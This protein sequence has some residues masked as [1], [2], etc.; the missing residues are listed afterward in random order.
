MPTEMQKLAD[1]LKQA[2]MTPMQQH[3][4]SDAYKAH[5]GSASAPSARPMG[6]DPHAFSQHQSMM[7]NPGAYVPQGQIS[8]GLELATPPR[9]YKR[10][11]EIDKLAACLKDNKSW[12]PASKK[13][14]PSAM[15]GNEDGAKTSE[16][17]KLAELMQKRAG[18]L[19]QGMH[20][21]NTAV[22][23]PGMI[24]R[25]A[26]KL[27]NAAGGGFRG[28]GAVAE[29]YAPG[30]AMI[31]APVAAGALGMS[32]MGGNGQQQQ[33]PGQVRMAS[34]KTGAARIDEL[35]KAAWSMTEP[36]HALDAARYNADSEASHKKVKAHGDYADAEGNRSDILTALDVTRFLGM[37]PFGGGSGSHL[38]PILDRVNSRHNDYA[39]KKH[40]KGENAYNPLGGWLTKSRH[41]EK[42]E[43]K[44]EKTSSFEDAAVG[45]IGAGTSPLGAGFVSSLIAPEG[46][47]WSHFG[48]T[49]GGALAGQ[50]AGMIA[51]ALLYHYG[52]KSPS[53]RPGHFDSLGTV[54][55]GIGAGIGHHVARTKAEERGPVKESSFG[56][57]MH[58]LREKIAVLPLAAA[59]PAAAGAAKG[60]LAGA[61]G[62]YVAGK[63]VPMAMNAGMNMLGS[64]PGAG[65]KL[66]AGLAGA[67]TGL[68]PGSGIASQV[69]GMAAQPLANKAFGVG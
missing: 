14:A 15:N 7:Q 58:A 60:L 28:V 47:G 36:G 3:A 4:V 42:D 63:A 52:I 12:M 33:Q 11:S 43:G 56:P 66:K 18:F 21:L 62:R 26:G 16:V 2:K 55:R 40:E 68:I 19:Q 41:E 32:M 64:G 29:H 39:A 44:R 31:A 37:Q 30:A 59:V 54:G 57:Q 69:A 35:S 48:H 22:N 65:N 8:S 49:G 17:Q 53:I 5:A 46:T 45:G 10:A 20:Q 34:V 24:S 25:G 38:Q 6:R 50:T 23:N 67:A 9:M 1:A 13:K 51:S 61:A 27:Y